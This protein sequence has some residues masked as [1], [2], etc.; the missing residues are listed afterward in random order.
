MIWRIPDAAPV[1]RAVLAALAAWA[2]LAAPAAAA[3]FHLYLL[4]EGRVA[5]RGVAH[6]AQLHLAL[7]DNNMTALI[8][9]SNL[10]PV[11]E[12]MRYTASATAYT[13][14][15]RTPVA[16]SRLYTDWFGTRLFVWMP[17][18]RRLAETRLT[19]D[20]QSAELRGELLNADGDTLGQLR[21]QCE[22]R[23]ADDLP[24]PKF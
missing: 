1:L 9:R 12:R 4:C 19:I 5:S 10:L 13:M 17:D 20:R 18:L 15:Y 21:M 3:E 24:E 11:G 14:S 16:G 22:P 8:Q 2:G 23:Q 7:R 6:D